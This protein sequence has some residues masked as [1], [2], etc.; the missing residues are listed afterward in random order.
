M[1]T[2][3]TTAL[4]LLSMASCRFPSAAQKATLSDETYGPF[5]RNKMDVYLPGTHSSS[6]PVVM[7]IHGGGWVAGNKTDWPA[8]VI[9]TIKGE[10][11]AVATINYRYADGDFRHQMQDVQMAIN[12]INSKAADWNIGTN[13]FA[14]MGASAGAHMS[15]LYAHGFDTAQVVKAVISMAGPCDMADSVFQQYANNYSIGY[16]FQQFLGATEQSNPQVYYDASPVNYHKQVPTL[17]FHGSLDNLVPP[18]HSQRMFDTLTAYGVITDTT[19]FGNAGHDVVGPG[20]VN[21][22]QIYAEVKAWLALY[23]H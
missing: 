19:F 9:N 20:S 21:M 6:T 11:Y 8:E 12:Y 22:T 5:A 15:L 17:L 10:G 4:F 13:R 16:V 23:L 1:R 18:A 3:L 7:L 14:L 2:I